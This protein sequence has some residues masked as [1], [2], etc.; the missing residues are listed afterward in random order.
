MVGYNEIAV[1]SEFKR[2]NKAK[3]I[4]YI[5]HCFGKDSPLI[6]VENF[7]ER[8]IKAAKKA[9]MDITS[10][11]TLTIIDFRDFEVNGLINTFLG[12]VQNS[13]LYDSLISNQYLFWS[14]QEEMRKPVD[15]KKIKE[16]TDLSKYSETIEQ[17]I[18]V[19]TKKIY[20]SDKEV[21]EMGAKVI[22]MSYGQR[23]KEKENVS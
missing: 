18:L 16:R 3:I 7:R 4:K 10:D 14:I 2:R 22:R 15:S 12:Q 8:Q 13:N 21:V 17:R 11:D 5:E 23:V 9:R 20:G 1:F 6:K 19:L